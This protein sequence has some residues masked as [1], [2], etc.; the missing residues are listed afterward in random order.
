MAQLWSPNLGRQSRANRGPM[1]QLW[2]PTEIR[3][4]VIVLIAI[5]IYITENSCTNNYF[6]ILIRNWWIFSSIHD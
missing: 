2:Q 1:D 6:N 5:T 4:W 3:T